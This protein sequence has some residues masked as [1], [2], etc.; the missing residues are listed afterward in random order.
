MQNVIPATSFNQ[1]QIAD[2]TVMYLSPTEITFQEGFNPRKHF[3]D[4]EF[5]ELCAS[6][7]EQGV[8]Q[9]IIVRPAPEDGKYWVVA[10]ERRW[11]AASKCHLEEIPAVV[12]YL[13]DHSA[14]K[15]ALIENS[16]R[17]DMSRSEEAT[18]ANI[19]VDVCGGDREEAAKQ[20]GWSRS[21]LDAR[22]M[23][24]HCS[25]KV[26]EALTNRTIKLGHAELLSQLPEVTQNGTLDKIIGDGI[27][28]ADLRSRISGFAQSLDTAIFNTA[29]CVGCAHNSTLQASLFEAVEGMSGKCADRACFAAKTEAALQDRKTALTD[30]YAAVWL[31]TEKRSGSWDVIASTGNSGVGVEQAAAC[32]GCGNFGVLMDTSPDRLGSL[33]ADCCFDLSCHKSKVGAYQKER[34]AAV[35]S[36]VTSPKAAGTASAGSTVKATKPV[37]ATVSVIPKKVTENIDGF[38]RGLSGAVVGSD[39]LSI[40]VYSAYAMLA[41]ARKPQEIMTRFNLKGHSRSDLT[42]QLFAI[43]DVHVL[44]DLVSALAVYVA[45]KKDGEGCGG[46]EMTNTSI[47]T[48]A[49]NSTELVG[50]W[51]LNADFL[52]AHTKSGIESLLK[53][54]GFDVWYN[55]KHSDDKSKAIPFEKFL[56]L[57]TADL[58]DAIIKSEFDFDTFVPACVSGRLTEAKAKFAAIKGEQSE[59]NAA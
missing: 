5:L 40:M 42:H 58:I 27:S 33:T 25:E 32:R 50:H 55:E 15:L 19:L 2:G 56:K 24:L 36:A 8:I 38:Y 11:R 9:P 17:A 28:V 37:K 4:S 18:A 47:T 16:T 35:T 20:L 45:G 31:D 39:T 3:A 10:G 14:F 51:R 43:G 48:L 13:D 6:V 29:E 54:A 26:Q 21:K 53:E 1:A 23:L 22:L 12:R 44:R 34:G 30:E 46:D 59:S 57:K 41:D 7:K 49:A 52:K